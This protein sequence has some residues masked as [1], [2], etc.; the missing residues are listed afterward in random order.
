[1]VESH[2]FEKCFDWPKIAREGYFGQFFSFFCELL[3]NKSPPEGCRFCQLMSLQRTDTFVLDG[4]ESDV[5]F[6]NVPA[7]E[8]SYSPTPALSGIGE[9]YCS[10]F[11]DGVIPSPPK[12]VR[13]NAGV[14]P[15]TPRHRPQPTPPPTMWPVDQVLKDGEALPHQSPL[16]PRDR[17]MQRVAPV[18]VSPISAQEAEIK[19]EPVEEKESPIS[20]FR[21][22]NPRR[23]KGLCCFFVSVLSFCCCFFSVVNWFFFLS[24]VVLPHLSQT[25]RARKRVRL[26]SGHLAEVRRRFNEVMDVIDPMCPTCHRRLSDSEPSCDS[27]S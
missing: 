25:V 22:P 23:K 27:C 18:S 13:Q 5:Q 24:G 21:V 3:V 14:W 26:S 11:A 10:S 2:I 17:A 1:M 6:D 12:L 19:T 16:S 20:P 4:E 15:T 7:F 9:P 8:P